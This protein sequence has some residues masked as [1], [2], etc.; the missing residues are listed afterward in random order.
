M[1]HNKA[2]TRLLHSKKGVL[3]L[4]L[5]NKSPFLEYSNR[6]TALIRIIT[7]DALHISTLIQ[8]H[9][10]HGCNHFKYVLLKVLF[11]YEPGR[12]KVGGM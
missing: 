8:L 12:S 9:W 11:G 1:M 3:S 5:K 4:N 6:V 10:R 7:D 2:V